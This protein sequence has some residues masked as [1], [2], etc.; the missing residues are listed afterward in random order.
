MSMDSA[1]APESQS[2]LT[3]KSNQAERL[4]AGPV[5]SSQRINSLD[6]LRGFALCGILLMN[7][8][9]FAWPGGAYG[10]P[11]FPYYRLD[12][13]GE[14][15]DPDTKAK[16]IATEEKGL[17]RAEKEKRREER[18]KEPKPQYANGQ[19]AWCAI[20]SNADHY[21]WAF[22]HLLVENKMRTLFSTLFGAGVLLM[23]ANAREKTRHP[24]WLHYR[25]MFWLLVFGALHAYL[26]WT[27]DILFAYASIGLWLYPLRNLRARVLVGFGLFLLLTPLLLAAAAPWVIDW[28]KERGRA[29]EHRLKEATAGEEHPAVEEEAAN[30]SGGDDLPWLDA[31]FL[32]GYRA[33]EGMRRRGPQPEMVTLNIR[34]YREQGYLEGVTERFWDMIWAQLAE[35][36]IGIL[37]LGWPMVLGMGLM[38]LG[39]FS[40][41]WET[42]RY[43]WWALGLYLLGIPMTWWGMML[44]LQGG[45]SLGTQLRVI[46][47]LDWVGS[48]FLTLAHAS[49]LLWLW[50]T[51]RL[52]WLAGRLQ[53]AGRMALS[54]YLSHSLICSLIFSGY[55]LALYGNLPR[56]GLAALVAGIWVFQLAASPWWLARFRFGPAEWLWRSLTYWKLQP[57]R[58]ATGECP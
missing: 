21:E 9:N 22:A 55:G 49:A 44:S 26:L 30:A 37:G 20:A 24:G 47:P 52:D 19:L 29:V 42:S 14:V 53:A 16:E 35:L 1:P 41:D 57:M 46:L 54:N 45:N 2:G 28:V 11:T 13:I 5:S 32:A 18:E 38:K 33:L 27:G 3:I 10:S 25:R 36:L 17:T 15:P 23:T 58:V 39:F 8:V 40:G 34:K 43:G 50:K 4:V 6:L 7:I 12:S 56:T 48:L 31:K 51:G